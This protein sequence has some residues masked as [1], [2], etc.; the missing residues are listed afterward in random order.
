MAQHDKTTV[1]YGSEV[2]FTHTPPR[3]SFNFHLGFARMPA[4]GQKRKSAVTFQIDDRSTVLARKGKQKTRR[5]GFS[6]MD[7][8]MNYAA[9]CFLRRA[10]NPIRPR[11]AS[12]IA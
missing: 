11:P 8:D 5:S 6:V 2:Y 4:F 7:D 1:R 9:F 12:S 10:T 3:Y